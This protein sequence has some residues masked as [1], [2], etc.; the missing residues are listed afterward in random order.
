MEDRPRRTKESRGEH[1]QGSRFS[2]PFRKGV[3]RTLYHVLL[4]QLGYYDDEPA[5][6]DV[7]DGFVYPNGFGASDP[8]Q[9]QVTWINHSTFLIEVEGK[10][11]LTDPVWSE[12]ASPFKSIGPK[13][14]HPPPFDLEQLTPIDYVLISHNH[15]DHLDEETVKR[16]SHL[17]PDIQWYV[18]LGVG[19][20]VHKMGARRVIELDWWE[21][22]TTP[23]PSPVEI[24][25]VPAQHYS[26]R[27]ILD[28]NSSLWG[29]WV[30]KTAPDRHFYFAGDTGYNAVQFKE[31]GEAF[32][33]I[34]LSLI[35]IGVYRPTAF[36]NPVHTNPKEAVEIHLD[37]NSQLSIGSHWG[38]F[39]L[40]S[41]P[42][43]QPPYDL[44]LC[45]QALNLPHH[46]FRVL[47]PG[48]SINW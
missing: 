48:Q 26:G 33:Q 28:H 47:E 23:G 34:D 5:L 7:P 27:G 24:H 14:M 25:A 43:R 42:V 16:L 41:E 18:P 3:R 46:T 31:I 20:L 17:F 45:M 6:P 37:V 38:T 13:R 10:T 12:R 9:P 15:Y 40:S 11:F 29:G 36:M 22:H 30:V 2:N 4:W 39:R 19:D 21:A 35:P 44:F 32:G 8:S 1:R